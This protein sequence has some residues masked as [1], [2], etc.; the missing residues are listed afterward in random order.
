MGV[1][2]SDWGRGVN[3][4]HRVW[5]PCTSTS[6]DSTKSY[7]CLRGK[8]GEQTENPQLLEVCLSAKGQEPNQLLSNL[9]EYSG[10]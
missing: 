1:P 6:T 10:V 7:F 5:E 2:E 4:E 9:G 3:G 8:E